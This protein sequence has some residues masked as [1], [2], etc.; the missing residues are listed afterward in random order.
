MPKHNFS[1]MNNQR[2]VIAVREQDVDNDPINNV[3]TIKSQIAEKSVSK[4]VVNT[5]CVDNKIAKP[6]NGNDLTPI[7]DSNKS[8][9]LSNIMNDPPNLTKQ[10]RSQIVVKP[11]GNKSSVRNN[12]LKHFGKSDFILFFCLIT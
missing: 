8:K 7:S 5:V 3:V 12:P 10:L 9:T 4:S 6:S 2:C 11:Q 1:K